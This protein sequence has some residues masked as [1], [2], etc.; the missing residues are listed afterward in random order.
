MTTLGEF[1]MSCLP[2]D[3]KSWRCAFD[4]DHRIP[5]KSS[6]YWC[7]SCDLHI[8]EHRVLDKCPNCGCEHLSDITPNSGCAT[9]DIFPSTVCS[10]LLLVLQCLRDLATVQDPREPELARMILTNNLATMLLPLMVKDPNCEWNNF[11]IVYSKLLMS[12]ET[13]VIRLDLAHLGGRLMYDVTIKL[14]EG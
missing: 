1:I 6:L 10:Q 11:E 12:S 3:H 5:E 9:V 2:I 13:I 8:A 14:R 7:P 4:S